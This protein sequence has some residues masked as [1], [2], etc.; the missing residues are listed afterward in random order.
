V[1]GNKIE[2]RSGEIYKRAKEEKLQGEK[3]MGPTLLPV[4]GRSQAKPSGK[5]NSEDG[6]GNYRQ[7]ADWWGV[8]QTKGGEDDSPGMESCS[9]K[10]K[11]GKKSRTDGENVGLKKSK[12]SRWC[13]PKKK[14]L[15]G[16]NF[17][18]KL[19]GT[20]KIHHRKEEK[21]PRSPERSFTDP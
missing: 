21:R 11:G 14:L 4:L 18:Q 20:K 5:G 10:V 2:L 17:A 16:L 1:T 12:T 19:R 7:R 6:P 15:M 9:A 13:H 3:H 8:N